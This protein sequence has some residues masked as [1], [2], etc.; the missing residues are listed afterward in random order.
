MAAD[1]PRPDVLGDL[2]RNAYRG[3]GFASTD[4]SLFKNFVLPKW[5]DAKIQFRFE[6]F[7]VFNRVNLRLPERQHGAGHFRTIDPGVRC[8]RDAVCAQADLLIDRRPIEQEK[9][10]GLLFSSPVSCAPV[11]TS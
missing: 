5:R 3:P 2:P 10:D 11:A 8:T 1:F 7:N 6:V 4:L 9:R